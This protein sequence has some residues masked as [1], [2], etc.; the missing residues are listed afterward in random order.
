M[1]STGTRKK[2]VLPEGKQP[3]KKTPSAKKAPETGV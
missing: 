3:V 1:P 2:R